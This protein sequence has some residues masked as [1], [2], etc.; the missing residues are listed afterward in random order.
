MGDRPTR[1]KLRNTT[2]MRHYF[3]F[4][5]SKEDYLVSLARD[6]CQLLINKIWEVCKI[7]Q[8]FRNF[9]I[10]VLESTRQNGYGNCELNIS[11]S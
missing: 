9:Y 11:C 5:T 1:V 4:R 3:H 7:L 6:N 8:Q 2:N 10:S